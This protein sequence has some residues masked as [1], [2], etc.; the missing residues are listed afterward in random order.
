VCLSAELHSSGLTTPSKVVGVFWA[1]A[2]KGDN[3]K[4]GLIHMINYL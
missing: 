4:R 1:K 3:K 2:R